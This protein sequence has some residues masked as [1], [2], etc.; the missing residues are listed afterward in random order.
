MPTST[1]PVLPGDFFVRD[2]KQFK[3]L[4]IRGVMLK[5]EGQY[6]AVISASL[7]KLLQ[8]RYTHVSAVRD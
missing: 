3:V 1:T 6:G 8:N 2:E 4:G 5:L 7:D